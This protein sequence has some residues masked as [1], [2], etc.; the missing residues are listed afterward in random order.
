VFYVEPGVH[1]AYLG[2]LL[3]K[4]QKSSPNSISVKSCRVLSSLSR[5]E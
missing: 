5:R 1:L 2:S 3:P 4:I